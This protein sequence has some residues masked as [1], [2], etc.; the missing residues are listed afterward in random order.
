MEAGHTDTWRIMGWIK[1]E[2]ERISLVQWPGL[3]DFS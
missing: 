2:D 1:I 3:S